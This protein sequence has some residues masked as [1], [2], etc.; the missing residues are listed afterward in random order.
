MCSSIL[1]IEKLLDSTPRRATLFS[2]TRL[3]HRHPQKH[4]TQYVHHVTMDFS[5]YAYVNLVGIK[6]PFVQHLNVVCIIHRGPLWRFYSR[7]CGTEQII[8]PS[9]SPPISPLMSS[10]LWSENSPAP[11]ASGAVGERVSERA[12]RRYP[13]P[14]PGRPPPNHKARSLRAGV[15]H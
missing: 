11:R 5:K 4:P 1:N 3:P 6:S 7:S 12:S 10:I 13:S 8:F 9:L 2:L 15:A 14:T